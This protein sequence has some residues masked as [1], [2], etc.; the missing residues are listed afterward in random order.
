MQ[1]RRGREEK[2]PGGKTTA[3]VKE[4]GRAGAKLYHRHRADWQSHK[5]DGYIFIFNGGFSPFWRV[6]K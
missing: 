3:G 1:G 6:L 4:R 2:V 5:M